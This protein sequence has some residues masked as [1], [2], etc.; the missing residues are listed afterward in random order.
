MS[1]HNR[2]LHD[3][4]RAAL[5]DHVKPIAD[6]MDVS[7]NYLHQILSGYCADPY[8]NFRPLFKAVLRRNTQ[9]GRAIYDDLHTLYMREMMRRG[10]YQFAPDAGS[11]PRVHKEVAEAVQAQLEGKNNDQQAKEIRE[12]IEQLQAMLFKVYERMADPDG[13]TETAVMFDGPLPH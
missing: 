2:P 6:E 9:A 11:L 1:R 8:A 7:A 10:A 12:A 5:T 3:L 4:T 13:A